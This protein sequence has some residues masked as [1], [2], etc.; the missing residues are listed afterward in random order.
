MKVAVNTQLTKEASVRKCG[1]V[2]SVKKMSSRDV[3]NE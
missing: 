1:G 2:G 3:G